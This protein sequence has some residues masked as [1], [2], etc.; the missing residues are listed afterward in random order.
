VVGIYAHYKY[1][2]TGEIYQLPPVID[3]AV[4]KD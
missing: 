3:P 2:Y 1:L 4:L